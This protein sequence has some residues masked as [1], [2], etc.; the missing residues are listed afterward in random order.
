[1][2]TAFELCVQAGESPGADCWPRRGRRGGGNALSCNITISSRIMLE[3]IIFL[4]N[5]RSDLRFNLTF[6]S[7]TSSLSVQIFPVLISRIVSKSTKVA[8]LRWRRN[9]W[10][11][12]RFWKEWWAN[13]A[14]HQL[15]FSFTFT[16]R[17][18]WTHTM[19]S[20]RTSDFT[21]TLQMSSS[22]QVQTG[23]IANSKQP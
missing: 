9:C 3:D 19:T 23:S 14:G 8:F 6:Q 21:K 4:I 22:S 17:W 7:Q 16:M 13:A 1:M 10:H 15:A 20:P 12:Q 18:I 2:N 11:L 5:T